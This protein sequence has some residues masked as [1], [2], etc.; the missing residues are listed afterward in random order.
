MLDEFRRWFSRR[1]DKSDA[2]T[3]RRITG[4][5]L[6]SD[7]PP[8]TM[9]LGARKPDGAGSHSLTAAEATGN[10]RDVS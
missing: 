1:Y 5:A 2:R 4:V 9:E 7:T 6:L 10:A 3:R 8:R